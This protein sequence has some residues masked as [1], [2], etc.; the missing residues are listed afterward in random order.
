[1]PKVT[2]TILSGHNLR[3]MDL[4]GKS[5]P[6]V[7]LKYDNKQQYKTSIVKANLNPVWNES[8]EFDLQ[9]EAD[10]VHMVVYDYDRLT[11][12]DV[13]GGATLSFFGLRRGVPR[14][15]T[16]TLSSKHDYGTIQ[17]QVIAQDFGG[18]PE[19]TDVVVQSLPVP[20]RHSSKDSSAGLIVGGIL[21]FAFL[22]GTGGALVG[23]AIGHTLQPKNHTFQKSS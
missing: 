14:I 23:A 2:V 16:Y 21:G 5:D 18:Y 20:I 15:D 4:N 8:F 12:N 1:M 22:G 19:P 3:A 17:L 7:V 10:S 11:Q 6:F 9:S 13:I